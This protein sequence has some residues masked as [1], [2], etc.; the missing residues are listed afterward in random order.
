MT[1]KKSFVDQQVAINEGVTLIVRTDLKGRITDVNSTFIEVS[2]YSRDELI[3]SNSNIVR[4]PDTPTALYER[5][6]SSL[7][8]GH[9]WHGVI[10]NRSKDGLFFWTNTEILPTSDEFEVKG[11]VNISHDCSAEQA[12]QAEQFFEQLQVNPLYKPNIGWWAALKSKLQYSIKI[13][14]S[15]AQISSVLIATWLFF[16]LAESGYP[17]ELV[18]ATLL[19]LTSLTAITYQS[20]IMTKVFTQAQGILIDS[21]QKQVTVIDELDKQGAVADFFRQI[22]IAKGCLQAELV[23][24]QQQKGEL[25]AVNKALEGI[26]S[27]VM[28]LDENLNISFVNSPAKQLLQ[29]IEQDIQSQ[30]PE[31]SVKSIIGS[32]ID[33]FFN[34]K[35]TDS[36]FWQHLKQPLRGQLQFGETHLSYI[37][38]PVQAPEQG[39]MGILIE[40]SDRTDTHIVEQSIES[41]VNSFI[42][43]D[44]TQRISNVHHLSQYFWVAKLINQLGETLEQTT[45]QLIHCFKTLPDDDNNQLLK[46]GQPATIA[47]L[48]LTIKQHFQQLSGLAYDLSAFQ[49]QLLGSVESAQSYEQQLFESKERQ[50]IHH[51]HFQDKTQSLVSSLSESGAEEQL[52]ILSKA[53][54]SDLE[55]ANL[56]TQELDSC[57]TQLDQYQ[58]ELFD[59]MQVMDEI[60]FKV[61]LAVMAVIGDTELNANAAKDMRG[62]TQQ[63]AL[64][65]RQGKA[66]LEE[67][68]QTYQQTKFQIQKVQELL[69]RIQQLYQQVKQITKQERSNSVDQIERVTAI[70]QAAHQ[71]SENLAQHEE[72]FQ[73]VVSNSLALQEQSPIVNHL[74]TRFKS[75]LPSDDSELQKA[76]NINDAASGKHKKQQTNHHQNREVMSGWGNLAE[77]NSNEWEEF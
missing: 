16:K 3:G 65:V 73:E 33:N 30:S 12:H 40:W 64:E 45:H 55:E 24:S 37:A 61:N 6:W 9:P 77:N 47:A 28:L 58:E 20:R 57:L 22:I 52:D 25:L 21:E 74:L 27:A 10:K 36:H 18:V 70:N 34:Y 63:S 72:L 1:F 17:L 19:T 38:S 76:P 75:M 29:S 62:L 23:Y 43:G 66:K 41:V 2:G 32:S 44:L 54:K 60:T 15:I 4:H 71:I 49:D 35:E 8:R 50:T 14:S 26:E 59:A 48:E 31:F 39:D 46:Q 13:T 68:K 67:S 56:S 53:A 11:Y 5:L 51:Q 42:A 69:N 7:K